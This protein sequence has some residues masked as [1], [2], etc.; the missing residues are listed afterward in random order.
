MIGP[1]EIGRFRVKRL[2]GGYTYTRS[3]AGK[4][5]AGVVEIPQS[6]VIDYIWSPGMS[7]VTGYGLDCPFGDGVQYLFLK[8]PV[9]HVVTGHYADTHTG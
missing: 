9:F 3:V 4:G 8:T 5:G 2:V 1:F 7:V 6:V